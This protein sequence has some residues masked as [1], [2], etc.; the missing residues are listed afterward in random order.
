MFQ[1][2]TYFLE[3]DGTADRWK[4]EKLNWEVAKIMK[5]FN[6]CLETVLNDKFLILKLFLT[7]IFLKQHEMADATGTGWNYLWQTFLFNLERR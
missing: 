3:N 1:Y 7:T 4:W 5:Y 2:V 6:F